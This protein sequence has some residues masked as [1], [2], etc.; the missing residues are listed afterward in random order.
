MNLARD[1][2]S[3]G[4]TALA[5]LVNLPVLLSLGVTAAQRDAVGT[6]EPPLLSSC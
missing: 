2:F 1:S 6:T 3:D 5:H 4:D